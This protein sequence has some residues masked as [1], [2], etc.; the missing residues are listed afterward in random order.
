MAEDDPLGLSIDEL[1]P[2]VLPERGPLT[3]SGTVTNESLETWDDIY[4]YPYLNTDGCQ[5]DGICSGPMLTSEELVEAAASD[6]ALP[7]GER[8]VELDVRDGVAELGPGESTSYTLTVPQSVLRAELASREPGVYWFGVQAIGASASS[9]RDEFA[10]GRARTFLPALPT[11]NRAP[12]TAVDTAVVIPLRA[13]IDHAPNGALART[14]RWERWLSLDGPL[15][16]LLAFGDASGGQPVSW[17]LDPAVLDAVQ[18]LD[19]GN[20]ART[21]VDPLPPEQD[22]EESQDPGDTG[23]TGT[24]ETGGEQDPDAD[25]PVP[26]DTGSSDADSDQDADPD[27]DSDGDAAGDGETDLLMPAVRNARPW[28]MQARRVLSESEVLSLPYGDPDL[29]GADGDAAAVYAQAAGEPGTVAEDWELSSTPAITG[30]DGYLSPDVLTQ[31]AALAEVAG[32]TQPD[33][34][35]DAG[36]DSSSGVTEAPLA[37]ISDAA[38]GTESFPDGAPADGN[39]GAIDLVVTSSGAAAGGPGP[40]ARL[41][42]VALRQRLLSE[43]ALRLLTDPEDPEPLVVQIPAEIQPAGADDFWSGLD[44]DWIDLGTVDELVD[45]P[46]DSGADSGTSGIGGLGGGSES[47]DTEVDAGLLTYPD[48]QRDAEVSFS[49][50]AEAQR[51]SVAGATLQNV[52]GETSQV[53]DEVTR[54]ALTGVSY[55]Q[56]GDVSAAIRLA[57]SR[58][59]ISRRLRS[60]RL[61]TPPGVTLASSS[62][63]FSVTVSND[64]DVPVTVV[65]AAEEADGA[66]IAPSE[67][68]MLGPN[69]RTSVSMEASTSSPGVHNVQL[70][71]TDV[72]GNTL[73]TYQTLRLRSGGVSVVIWGIIGAGVAILFLAIGI[74][75]VRRIRAR[76]SGDAA[77]DRVDQPDPA[78]RPEEGAPDRGAG[79][80]T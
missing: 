77:G 79:E 47:T 22:P 74:R 70:L 8:I 44:V 30:P 58:D 50:F 36:G 27:S 73:G 46:V 2:A 21:L 9:P 11:G 31:L 24:G 34:G 69:G 15:G 7:V 65:V 3:I 56:R 13:A 53:A 68:V 54:E 40:D 75:L 80:P 43:A 78:G 32:A 42:P 39:V 23:G 12:T 17:L 45:S 71:L 61:S 60:V 72:D 19:G 67:P 28:L 51:L 64:L 26:T 33:A 16:R 76:H 62:G 52:L 41:S 25:D 14:P 48:A 6:P 5:A 57:R 63:R 29:A 4:L 66:V 38:F 10:D 59:W 18:A 49:V 37:L 1:S 35:E 20:P 55:A